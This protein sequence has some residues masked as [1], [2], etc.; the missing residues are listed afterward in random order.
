MSLWLVQLSSSVQV[1]AADAES[2][3]EAA[4]GLVLQG[5]APPCIRVVG[6]EPMYPSMSKVL[7][8]E[9]NEKVEP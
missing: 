6:V 1:S 8:E 9:A 4:E 3:I 7:D 5:W 2:A